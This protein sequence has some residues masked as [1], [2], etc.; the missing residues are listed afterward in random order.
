M[1]CL[2]CVAKTTDIMHLW[3]WHDLYRHYKINTA[4]S[5]RT[6]KPSSATK[7]CNNNGVENKALKK[8]HNYAYPDLSYR[9]GDWEQGQFYFYNEIPK[10]SGCGVILDSVP[11][12]SI[13]FLRWNIFKPSILTS[14]LSAFY[15]WTR[16]SATWLSNALIMPANTCLC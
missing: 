2:I 7:T 6:Y 4:A 11:E 3:Q 12:L 1:L 16:G 14:Q 8:L 13:F 15:E 9:N 10:Y 5:T